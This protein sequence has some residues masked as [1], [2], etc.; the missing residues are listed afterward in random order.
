MEGER[1][2]IERNV[3]SLP[4]A[5]HQFLYKATFQFDLLIGF[6]IFKLQMNL[7]NWLFRQ[8]FSLFFF[9][10]KRL[11]SHTVTVLQRT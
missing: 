5:P 4:P 11:R 10:H 6:F 8:P 7:A 2:Q 1:E 3:I 9:A